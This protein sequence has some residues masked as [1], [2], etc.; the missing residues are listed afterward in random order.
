MEFRIAK[1]DHGKALELFTKV[2]DYQRSHPEI[3]YYA[4]SRSWFREAPDNP[5]H[6]IWMS[7]MNDDR[8]K[9][10]NSLQQAIMKETASADNNRRWAAILVPGTT[11]KVHEVW[12]ELEELRVEF[13]GR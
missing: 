1:A 5:N 11:P 4:R 3:Y 2:L 13:E 7:S 10:W 6:E 9:Y 12:T 8:E